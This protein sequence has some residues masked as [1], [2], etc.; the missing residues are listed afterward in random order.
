MG[1]LFDG[2]RKIK[3]PLMSI[4]EMNHG[5]KEQIVEKKQ[6]FERIAET[7]ALNE[8]LFFERLKKEYRSC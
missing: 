8:K 3:Q 6:R 7:N 2:K 4:A 5:I 1:D